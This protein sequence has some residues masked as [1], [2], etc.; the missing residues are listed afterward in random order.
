MTRILNN[1]FQI[2]YIVHNA[3]QFSFNRPPNMKLK[4]RHLCRN[5]KIHFLIKRKPQTY[6]PRIAWSIDH[7]A[8]RCW[9]YSTDLISICHSFCFALCKDEMSAII[10]ANCKAQQTITYNLAASN[11]VYKLC[12]RLVKNLKLSKFYETWFPHIYG[13]IHN[14]H[15]MTY[16]MLNTNKPI[17]NVFTGKYASIIQY[18]LYF[19]RA[20]EWK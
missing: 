16:F 8:Y 14:Q 7:I 1:T 6:P 19:E 4:K 5:L 12:N 10:W 20:L 11:R 9:P 2:G 17:K 13:K 15:F 18:F 3:K